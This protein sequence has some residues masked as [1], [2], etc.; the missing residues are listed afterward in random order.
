MVNECPKCGNDLS[1]M[2]ETIKFCP[3]CQAPLDGADTAGNEDTSSENGRNGEGRRMTRHERM[4]EKR[5]RAESA[6]PEELAFH[7]V[8]EDGYYDEMKPDDDAQMAASPAMVAAV[9]IICLILVG[10]I[11][12]FALYLM[13]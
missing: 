12:L 6:T 13:S 8:N 9:V 1:A 2:P 10:V 7:A 5:L 4:M 11:T 3:F